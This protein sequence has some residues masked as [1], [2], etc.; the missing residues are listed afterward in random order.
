MRIIFRCGSHFVVVGLS[1]VTMSPV[2]LTLDILS[3]FNAVV[4]LSND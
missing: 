2:T 4:L 3:D 1:V